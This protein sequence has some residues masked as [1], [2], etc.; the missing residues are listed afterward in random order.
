MT[1]DLLFSPTR[2]GRIEIANQIVMAPLTRSRAD[3]PTDLPSR[4]AAELLFAACQRRPGY[5]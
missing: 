4:F 3:D 1:Q 5:H 2:L